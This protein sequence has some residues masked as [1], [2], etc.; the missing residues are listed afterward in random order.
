MYATFLNNV[1]YLAKMLN[2]QYRIPNYA[3]GTGKKL[4]AENAWKRRNEHRDQK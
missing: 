4:I 2:T 1:L 3:I